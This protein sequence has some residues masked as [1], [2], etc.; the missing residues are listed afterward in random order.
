MSAARLLVC[1]LVAVIF[2]APFRVSAAD[3]ALIA[4]GRRLFFEETFDGNGRTCGSCHPAENNYTIDPAYIAN[5]PKSDPLLTA[6][7]LE[8][9]ELLR[10]L[11]LVTVHAD[12]F[13]RPGVPRSVPHLLGLARSLDHLEGA[14][15]L[16]GASRDLL[17]ATGW[18]G[19]GAPKP[20][21]LR[22]FAT[23]AVREHLTKSVARIEGRDFRLPTP[24][25]LDALAAFMRTL[26][27]RARD[28]LELGNFIGVTFRSKLVERGRF[29]FNNEV[30]GPCALCHRN[31]TG[32]DEGGFN[33]MFDIGVQRRRD[34]PARLLDPTVPPDGGF[35]PCVGRPTREGCGDGRFNVPSLIEAA[36][37]P[38]YF[39]DNSA[40]TI[41]QAIRFYT[42][43]TFANS[44]DGQALPVIR[45]TGPDINAIG[46]LLRTLNAI[47]NIRSAKA[48][49]VQAMALGLADGRSVL[50]LASADTDDA[51]ID[52]TG[53]P[54]LIN[55]ASTSL[56][57]SAR[58]LLA[59]ALAA[60]TTSVR[61]KA[62]RAAMAAET[63]ARA[64][65]LAN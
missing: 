27:R 25:E 61:D 26:G 35:G 52:L 59:E 19:D 45:L 24:H 53:G 55:V 46:A 4:E 6:A 14:L 42:T 33:G 63:R 34:T 10:K 16:P 20:G 41:E 39:H 37:T 5:L 49:M 40:A 30:S 2:A 57:R 29:L 7:F 8:R 58:G 22:A 15:T 54:V 48:F 44:V 21:N 47:E 65:M 11:A 31:A 32:L 17:H 9:P 18:S 51:A 56:L 64:Q 3:D 13:D 62:L 38:P 23:G 12:G 28:E 1:A 43:A 36:D 50:R 60:R